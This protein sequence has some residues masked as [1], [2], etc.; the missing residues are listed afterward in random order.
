[1]LCFDPGNQLTTIYPSSLVSLVIP[2]WLNMFSAFRYSKLRSNDVSE[3]YV[4]I[5]WTH[6]VWL[7]SG[8]TVLCQNHSPM[9]RY[10]SIFILVK[11]TSDIISLRVGHVPLIYSYCLLYCDSTWW[12]LFW[13]TRPRILLVRCSINFYFGK[14][15]FG[16][17]GERRVRLETGIWSGVTQV[18]EFEG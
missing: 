7:K 17:R 18:V 11:L 6:S 2:L 10:S 14:I 15:S 13:A 8:S 3:V 9:I 1:M 16:Y 5:V 4:E 12:S